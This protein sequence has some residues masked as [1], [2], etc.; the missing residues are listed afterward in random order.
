MT[1]PS[2]GT[3]GLGN[4]GQ[5]NGVGYELSAFYAYHGGIAMGDTFPEQLVGQSANQPINMGQ[6]YGRSYGISVPYSYYWQQ[7]ERGQYGEVDSQTSLNNWYINGYLV[8]YIFTVTYNNGL[9]YSWLIING[10]PNRYFFNNLY[11]YDGVAYTPSGVS[12]G[13]IYSYQQTGGYSYYFW[14]RNGANN[15]GLLYAPSYGTGSGVQVF[16][17]N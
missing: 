10:Y 13:A 16:R 4:D 3:L 11:G 14:Y 5:S 1:L 17:Y 7:G 12:G 2:S 9:A 8:Y 15:G 6:F